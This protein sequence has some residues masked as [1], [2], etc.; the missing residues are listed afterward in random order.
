MTF[1]NLILTFDNRD[2]L[3]SVSDFFMGAGALSVEIREKTPTLTAMVRNRNQADEL[4]DRFRTFADMM[5]FT[6][7]AVDFQTVTD[8]DWI[9]AFRSHFASFQMTPDLYI[10]PEWEAGEE[11][12]NDPGTIVVDPGQ[13]F[14]TGLHPTTA[15]AAQFLVEAVRASGSPSLLDVGCGSGILSV[16]AAKNGA[17][18][19]TAFDVDP[20]CSYA[21]QRHVQLN[22]LP[23]ETMRMFV[24]THQSLKLDKPVDLMV[25]NII[26][27]VI[28]SILPDIK[29]LVG[30]SLVLSGI[31]QEDAPAF[32]SWLQESR[33]KTTRH[34]V[35]DEWA[36]FQCE[37]V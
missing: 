14:G 25:I 37:P 6:E 27:S 22:N 5:G 1:I 12:R 16:A 2:W 7:P 4:L 35:R 33:F 15:L 8:T 23:F 31:L 29:H 32:V 17:E 26:E 3:A 36:A 20:L 11:H 18:E 19:I 21:V 13:A 28:R 9:A 24:G 10:V 30:G 34:T